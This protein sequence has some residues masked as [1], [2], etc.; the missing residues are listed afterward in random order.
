[1]SC[2][3]TLPSPELVEAYDQAMKEAEAVYEAIVNP[4]RSRYIRHR[5]NYLMMKARARRA[6]NAIKFEAEIAYS[7]AL[8]EAKGKA[9]TSGLKEADDA[10]L[11]IGEGIGGG[12]RSPAIPNSE[13]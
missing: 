5:K 9:E 1:M 2:M 11:G 13:F 7:R 3:D 12:G 6:R 4:A 8:R 10:S